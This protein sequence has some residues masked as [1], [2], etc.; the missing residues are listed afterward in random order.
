M[1]PLV[2]SC[3]FYTFEFFRGVTPQGTDQINT[4]I[5]LKFFQGQS[6]SHTVQWEGDVVLF[7]FAANREVI[8][9]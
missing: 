1:I 4:R 7:A 9:R 8:V 2:K 5:H 3:L 6:S